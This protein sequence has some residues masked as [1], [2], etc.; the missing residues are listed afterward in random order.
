MYRWRI[1]RPS[2]LAAGQPA[3]DEVLVFEPLVLFLVVPGCLGSAGALEA[4][5]RGAAGL[6]VERVHHDGLSAFNLTAAERAAL[7]L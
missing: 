4:G 6:R 1:Q 3:H 2:Y 7:T 5:E